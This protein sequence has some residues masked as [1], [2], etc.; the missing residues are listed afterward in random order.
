M[1]L[2]DFFLGLKPFG[3]VPLYVKGYTETLELVKEHVRI[4]TESDLEFVP[5]SLK[6]YFFQWNELIKQWLEPRIKTPFYF[7][8]INE[9]RKAYGFI[10]KGQEKQSIHFSTWINCF[11]FNTLF[12]DSSYVIGVEGIKDCYPF[13]RRGLSTIA[14]LSSRPNQALI[15]YIKQLGKKLIYICDNDSDKKSNTGQV[16]REKLQELMTGM[17]M[18]F[19]LPKLEEV[20][21]TG[22]WFD[23]DE[24]REKVEH[25]VDLVQSLV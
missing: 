10:L 9:G 19:V 5:N 15:K 24:K 2:T 1:V 6:R 8:P 16:Q 20:G 17:K 23:S 7:I 14:S 22:E 11:N 18:G 21:D 3:S 4:V 25:F 13:L 12:S